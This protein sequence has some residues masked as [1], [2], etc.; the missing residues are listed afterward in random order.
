MDLSNFMYWK[1]IDRNFL[2]L[3]TQSDPDSQTDRP[4]ARNSASGYSAARFLHHNTGFEVGTVDVHPYKHAHPYSDDPKQC[5]RR[6]IRDCRGSRSSRAGCRLGR[7]GDRRFWPRFLK[8]QYF[9]RLLKRIEV[10]LKTETVCVPYTPYVGTGDFMRTTAY[11]INL[12][13]IP[14][15]NT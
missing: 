5:I 15:K 2:L 9:R 4:Q 12:L 14:I 8:N 10:V 13:N 6:I 3:L 7:C 11:L 1:K